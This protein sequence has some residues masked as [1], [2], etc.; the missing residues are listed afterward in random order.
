MIAHALVAR[1]GAMGEMEGHA[2]SVLRHLEAGSA[3]A[4]G[5]A[6][7]LLA[8]IKRLN[9]LSEG[10]RRLLCSSKGAEARLVARALFARTKRDVWAGEADV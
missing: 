6:Q 2:L 1:D 9:V 5:A 10:E 7:R 8:L 4:L 3:R